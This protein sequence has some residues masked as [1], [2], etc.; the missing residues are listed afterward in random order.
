MSSIT[1]DEFGPEIV[2]E[3][4]DQKTG[5][6]GTLVIDNTARGLGKGGIRFVPDVTS[7]EVASLA[8]AMTWK[9][10]LA[11]LPFGG[12]KAGI[13]GDP[14]KVD[15]EAW[16]RSFARKIKE[17]VP[18]SYIA[19]PDMNTTEKEMAIIADEIGTPLAATGKPKSMGGLPHELGSTGFG[20]Y[21]ATLVA[22]GFKNI[23]V[24]DHPTVAI[25]GF[26][27]VG[28]FTMK[29]LEEKGFCIV[30]VS[31]SQGMIYNKNGLSFT[32][33]VETKQKHGTVTAY[34]DGERRPK[35]DLFKLDVAILIPGAR[36]NVITEKNVND[37]KAK[38]IV[39]AA[40]I[41]IPY[42]VEKI[43]MNRGVLVIPDFLANAGGVISSYCEYRG[44]NEREMFKIVEEKIIKN[45]EA[46][47]NST[48]NNDTRAA[49]LEIAKERVIDA[50]EKK[51]WLILKKKDL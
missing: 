18:H 21:C 11:D 22:C 49:A 40:N 26:G 42:D 38:I 4:Y 51:G 7:E 14:K 9:N 30:A 50:M 39:E 31:D 35:E 27:N 32:K 36:P 45:S 10:A 12:A 23:N 25:E 37:V 16:I 47:L 29:F 34:K 46:V 2:L 13:K 17:L 28:M 19:G 48:K 33:L 44:Y 3:V 43:L 5:M 24:D 41:P 1:R 15:K 6:Q 8:R 20:V